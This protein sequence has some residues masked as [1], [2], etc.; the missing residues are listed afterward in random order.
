MDGSDGLYGKHI[1]GSGGDTNKYAPNKDGAQCSDM[2]ATILANNPNRKA[3]AMRPKMV[4]R[5]SH[6][7]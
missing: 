4:P 7:S 3:N 6:K 1:L 5:T 2:D